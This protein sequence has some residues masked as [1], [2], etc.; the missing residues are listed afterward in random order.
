MQRDEDQSAITTKE[1][2]GTA[3]PFV[4]GEASLR[5]AIMSEVSRG[6][7]PLRC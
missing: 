3:R 6:L 1:I 5:R 7:E 4:D 2:S